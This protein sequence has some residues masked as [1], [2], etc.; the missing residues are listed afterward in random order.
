MKIDYIEQPAKNVLTSQ[1]LESQETPK[2]IFEYVSGIDRT[3]KYE[4]KR[5][6]LC[7]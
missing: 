6:K 5:L 1:N 3:E 2:G 4:I 7:A